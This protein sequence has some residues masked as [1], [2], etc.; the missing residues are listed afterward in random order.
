[1]C[2]HGQRGVKVQRTQSTIMNSLTE[3]NEFG[4]LKITKKHT[5][6]QS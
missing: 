5:Q 4:K 3:A 2:C 6:G 1:M